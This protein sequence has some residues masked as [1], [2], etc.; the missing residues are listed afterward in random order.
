MVY[1]IIPKTKATTQNSQ[2][3]DR[4]TEQFWGQR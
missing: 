4:A 3:A 1:V 2:N